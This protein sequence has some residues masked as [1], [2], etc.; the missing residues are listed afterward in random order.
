ATARGVPVFF[1][2]TGPWDARDES[3]L[4]FSGRFVAVTTALVALAIAVGV[5]LAW[6]NVRER[7]GDR[8][9][10]LR[11]GL[12]VFIL[13]AASQLI[14]ADHELAPLHELNIVRH[15]LAQ[16]LFAGTFLCLVYLAL[17]PHLRRRWP[18]RLVSWARL[19]SGNWRDPMVGRD[20]LIGL[21]VG[22][23]HGVLIFVAS[24]IYN[25][26]DGAGI[27]PFGNVRGLAGAHQGAAKVLESAS[28]GIVFAL[29]VMMILM[30]LTILL[31]RRAIAIGAFYAM[32]IAILLTGSTDPGWLPWYP[33]LA[34][35][36]TYAVVRY[37]LLAA[38]ALHFGFEIV[39]HFP[40]PDAIDW[41]TARTL[42]PLVCLLALAAWAFRTSLGDQKA[43][44]VSLE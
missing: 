20:I 22:V 25:I 33:L 14:V 23:L 2:I 13:T 1:R 29:I 34:G 3:S 41:Y 4:S 18:D 10:A 12:A 40:V 6:R 7:R 27:E 38:A 36:V 31:R 9:G 30:M 19:L 24:T 17:E 35:I 28:E 16:A 37:G 44:N 32:Y 11:V 39:L 43:F 8:A 26:A 5:L 42:V 21:L 15:A